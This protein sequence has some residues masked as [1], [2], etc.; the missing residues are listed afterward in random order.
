[1]HPLYL[2]PDYEWEELS[3]FPDLQDIQN[4][5]GIPQVGGQ[6]LDGVLFGDR[7]CD[8]PTKFG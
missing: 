1:M 8:S 6:L 2:P 5:E 7:M 4:V 3:M